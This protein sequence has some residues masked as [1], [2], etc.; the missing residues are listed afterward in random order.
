MFNLSARAGKHLLCVTICTLPLCVTLTS[1]HGQG[2][3]NNSVVLQSAL[4]SAWSRSPLGAGLKA[5]QEES[6][7]ALNSA[8][9]W[10]AGSPILGL[11]QRF[12]QSSGTADVGFSETEVSIATP[13]WW[14]G[15]KSARQ[16]LAGFAAEQLDAETIQAKLELAGQVREAY[17]Q[18]A[19][20]QED[21]RELE[22]HVQHLVD[23]AKDVARRVQAGDL[24]R[25]DGLLADQEVLHA[26][27]QWTAAKVE[28]QK[29]KTHYQTL[30]GLETPS[31][32]QVELQRNSGPDH[33]KVLLTRSSLNQA[34]AALDLA[35]R[36]RA[37]VPTV[38]VS[39]RNETD[40]VS[41]NSR[42]LGVHLQVPIGTDLQGKS[43]Q[44]EAQTRI[45]VAQAELKLVGTTLSNEIEAAKFQLELEQEG[46]GQA[47]QRATYASEHLALMQKAFRLGERGLIDLIRAQVL[48]HESISAKTKQQLKVNLAI[49]RLNQSFGVL[50]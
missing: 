49:S 13:V 21:V 33:P 26:K 9:S 7:A 27:T 8:N 34:R 41:P 6:K 25:S 2:M 42:A 11:S 15:Q 31:A 40:N 3:D 5:R 23:I 4:E 39:M 10:I 44:T 30:T 18:V 37:S 47:T 14:P 22:D 17:W 35:N 12:D 45:A 16:T 24:A 43:L 38:G 28:Y 19:I 50:P 1:A 29:R 32:F 46:L 36:S 20:A 48:I